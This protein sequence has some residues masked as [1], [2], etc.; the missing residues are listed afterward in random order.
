M[1]QQSNQMMNQNQQIMSQP[2]S[3]ITVKDHLY[4]ED[5]LSWNLNAVKKAHF[6][7]GQCQDQEIKQAIEKMAMTHQRHYQK[8]LAHLQKEMS[9]QLQPQGQPQ[10]G[11][12]Q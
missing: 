4:L 7:A 11:G 5:M 3:T 2:P 1:Q 12:M 6:F 9:S 8:L 10:I